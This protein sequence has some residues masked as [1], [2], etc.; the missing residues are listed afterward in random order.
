[1]MYDPVM[2]DELACLSAQPV[3]SDF[4]SS[5]KSDIMIWGYGVNMIRL[6]NGQDPSTFKQLAE[7]YWNEKLN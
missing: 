3:E 7:G 4:E 2:Y 6:A 5:V 1:M